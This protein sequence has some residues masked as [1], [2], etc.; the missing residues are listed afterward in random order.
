[1]VTLPQLRDAA[2][3]VAVG[4]IGTREQGG[5]NRGRRVEEYLAS[6]HL[7]PGNPWCLAFVI[8]CYQRAAETGGW[9]SPLPAIGAV[10]RFWRHGLMDQWRSDQPTIGAIALH[11][12]DPTDPWS[13]G[14]AGI[15]L[16]IGNMI[17]TV[18]GNTNG[19]GSREGDEVA[20]QHRDRAYWNLGYLDVGRFGPPLG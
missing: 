13:P 8:W 18:E 12:K 16:S 9:K 1:V 10:S 15:V 2:R 5:N 11:A 20:D 14:H 19:A 3:L 4:E 17:G 6:C 7:P